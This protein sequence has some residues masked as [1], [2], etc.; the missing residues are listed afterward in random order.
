M[1]RDAIEISSIKKGL[2]PKHKSHTA[3]RLI[4]PSSCSKFHRFIFGSPTVHWVLQWDLH[5]VTLCGAAVFYTS[6]SIIFPWNCRI[7][8]TEIFGLF[9]LCVCWIHSQR[10]KDS[11]FSSGDLALSAVWS[12][13]NLCLPRQKSAVAEVTYRVWFSWL[14]TRLSRACYAS[15]SFPRPLLRNDH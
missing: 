1:E 4:S 2:P 5:V 3:N 15:G 6:F 14:Q 10:S 12:S 9:D 11:R 13:Q 8:F 7:I